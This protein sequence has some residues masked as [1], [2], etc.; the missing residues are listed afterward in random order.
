ME[1]ESIVGVPDQTM[2]RL[3]NLR[4]EEMQRRFS[5]MCQWDR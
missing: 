5:K 4:T 3:K 2:R 1:K